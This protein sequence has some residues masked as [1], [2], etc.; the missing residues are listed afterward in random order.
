MYYK[1]ENDD[2]R[3]I[4]RASSITCTDY[5]LLGNFIPVENMLSIIDDLITE[6]ER[7]EERYKD[8]EQEVEENY[9]PISYAEQIGYNVKDFY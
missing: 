1:L 7:L 9:K 3:T 5:E 8:F 6:I 4:T 2:F